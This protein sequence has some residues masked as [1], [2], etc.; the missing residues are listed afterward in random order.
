MMTEIQAQMACEYLQAKAARI[1]GDIDVRYVDDDVF[2]IYRAGQ[3]NRLCRI[4]LRD[5][6]KKF[7]RLVRYLME[8]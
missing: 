2:T 7:E 1:G 4:S 6:E 3:P 5:P 8:D